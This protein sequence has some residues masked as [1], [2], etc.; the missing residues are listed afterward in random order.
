MPQTTKDDFVLATLSSEQTPTEDWLTVV[1]LEVRRFLRIQR[2]VSRMSSK[3]DEDP[4][5]PSGRP[6]SA[7]ARLYITVFS[8]ELVEIE[9]ATM[10]M[11]PILTIAHAQAKLQMHVFMLQ[12]EAVKPNP[13]DLIACYTSCVLII[14]TFQDVKNTRYWSDLLCMPLVV[15]SV[16]RFTWTHPNPGLCLRRSSLLT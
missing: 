13:D 10:P 16:R 15:A 9:R 2:F 12:D 5:T 8:Q 14:R 1:P 4:S 11:S 3:L 7:T 6:T